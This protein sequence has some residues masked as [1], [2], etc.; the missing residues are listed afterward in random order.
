MALAW[1]GLACGALPTLIWV[2]KSIAAYGIAGFM[3]PLNFPW[4]KVTGGETGFPFSSFFYY[5]GSIFFLHTIPWSPLLPLAVTSPNLWERKGRGATHG[6]HWRWLLFATPAVILLLLAFTSSQHKHY[7]LPIYPFAALLI[8][9]DLE[10]RLTEVTNSSAKALPGRSNGMGWQSLWRIALVHFFLACIILAFCLSDGLSMIKDIDMTLINMERLYAVLILLSSV[11]LL[12]GLM[13]YW[14]RRSLQQSLKSWIAC[15]I[16]GGYLVILVTVHLGFVGNY[17][18]EVKAFLRQ[19]Y[20]QNVLST[21]PVDLIKNGRVNRMTTL[22]RAYSPIM[23]R[24]WA[25]FDEFK[26]QGGP[27]AWIYEPDLKDLDFPYTILAQGHGV[28]LI[29]VQS[30]E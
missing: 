8:A 11:W 16:L 3:A 18:P 13:V 14:P 2:W 26:D 6:F 21:A 19:S 17:S 7:A 10:Y 28:L 22:L 23:G 30:R 24:S 29:H 4:R 27:L 1:P 5:F 9:A 20:I 25:S 12:A 15:H